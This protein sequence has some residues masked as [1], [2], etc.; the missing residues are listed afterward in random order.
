MV[1]KKVP[2]E[3]AGWRRNQDP[4]TLSSP[5]SLIHERNQ[6]ILDLTN[7]ITALLTG[8][9]PIRCQDVSIY[10]SLEEWDYIEEHKD[11]YED[12]V[13]ESHN[14]IIYTDESIK[15]ETPE[16][17]P[18][19]LC[20][21]YCP[22]GTPNSSQ[23][24]QVTDLS[25]VKVEHMT[26]DEGTCAGAQGEESLIDGGTDH[27]RKYESIL[28]DVRVESDRSPVVR[29]K[30]VRKKEGS[31]YPCSECGKFFTRKSVLSLHKRIH[32]DERPYACAHCGK[33]F[34]WK[35]DLTVHE[36]IHSGVKPYVCCECGKCLT[37]K[38]YLI[39]HM[40]SH[41]GEQPFSC[42]E[43][44]KCLKRKSLLL[45]HLRTHTGE[46]PF[47]CK[48]CGKCFSARSEVVTHR[49]IHT[50]EKPFSCLECGKCFTQR[51][52]L[53]MHR[54]THTGEK[55]YVCSECGKSFTRKFF[56]VEHLKTHT[57]E[58]P[59]SCTECGKCFSQKSDLVNHNLIHTGEKPFSCSECGKCYNHRSTLSQ[60]KKRK[61]F[62][63]QTVANILSPQ[64]WGHNY[65]CQ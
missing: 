5:H 45:K 6:E 37:R 15:E 55:P 41:T 24:H 59:H 23:D 40:R 12:I 50:G 19:P 32:T 43:C 42:S 39:E 25:D 17:S 60:H 16:P 53:I 9:V 52:G 44:G 48:E 21:N 64:T 14:T 30:R 49:V 26:E 29:K 62:N 4:I 7:K 3:G 1:V 2:E 38:S 10:F 58:K 63:V 8:E 47:A 36:R 57:G 18:S 61:H 22:E 33:R 51:S 35:T 28:E 27:E 34:R 31:V 13:I 65:E 11:V 56:L 20:A 54:R 46:K